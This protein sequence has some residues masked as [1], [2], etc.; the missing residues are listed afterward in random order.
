MMDVNVDRSVEELQVAANFRHPSLAWLEFLSSC[1]RPSCGVRLIGSDA[2]LALPLR[3]RSTCERSVCEASKSGEGHFR[4]LGLAET[5]PHPPPGTSSR[6]FAPL[7]FARNPTSPRTR[8][9]V[10]QAAPL[11]MSSTVLA[12]GAGRL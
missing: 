4:K 11:R 2:R 6:G 1:R 9:E 12:L 5:P 10:E 7:R 8:G 3:E